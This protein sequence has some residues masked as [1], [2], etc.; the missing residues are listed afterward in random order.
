MKQ[1]D[2]WNKRFQESNKPRNDDP[3]WIEKYWQ[4]FVAGKDNEI[5][6]LGCGRGHNSFYLYN[7]GFNVT[8]N[9]VDTLSLE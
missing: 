3:I 4:F 9:P 6:D 1:V 2:I 7:R 5:L 8:A